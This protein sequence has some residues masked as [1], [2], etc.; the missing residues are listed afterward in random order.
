MA[1]VKIKDNDKLI[2][3][4]HSKAILNTDRIAL[5]QYYTK[6]AVAKKQQQEQ[7]ETK[8]KIA[9]LEKDMSEIKDLLKQIALARK[10]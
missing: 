6:R 4:T 7:Y 2:R 1:Y 8:Q 5:E 10:S 3:D 9:Q